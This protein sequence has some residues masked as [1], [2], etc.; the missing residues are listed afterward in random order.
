VKTNDWREKDKK[1]FKEN[2]NSSCKL[3]IRIESRFA[4]IVYNTS[5]CK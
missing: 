4:F 1:Y 5:S 3:K 2:S